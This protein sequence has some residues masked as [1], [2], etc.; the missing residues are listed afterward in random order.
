VHLADEILEHFLGDG[1]VGDHAVL[2]RADGGDVARRAPEHV[3]GL[4]ADGLDLLAAARR[5]LADGHHG[6]LVEHDA[7]AADVDQG[8]G[9]AEV[10]RKVVRKI[11][12]KV[13]E[14]SRGETR[15]K[16]RAAHGRAEVPAI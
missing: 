16:R 5:F 10:D 12:A 14:H 13:L 7:L 6:G 11:A 1:E 9:S 15:R 4:G 2:E 8:V 3:L